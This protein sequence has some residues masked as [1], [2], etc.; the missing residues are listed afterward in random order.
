[1]SLSMSSNPSAGGSS[2]TAGCWQTLA[3]IREK[4]DDTWSW[5]RNS[6]TEKNGCHLC[7]KHLSCNDICILFQSGFLVDIKFGRQEILLGRI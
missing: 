6:D 4:N 2:L 1:M 3:T 7:R 5:V